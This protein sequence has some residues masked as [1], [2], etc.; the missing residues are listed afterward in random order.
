[1]QQPSTWGVAQAID[2]EKEIH[3]KG[4]KLI[5]ALVPNT[6]KEATAQGGT[7]SPADIRQL[8]SSAYSAPTWGLQGD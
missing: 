4:Q 2:K 1:M 7:G 5:R 3:R 6:Q 8:W